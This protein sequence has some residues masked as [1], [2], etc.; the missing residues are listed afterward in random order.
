MLVDRRRKFRQD[1]LEE[2]WDLNAGDIYHTVNVR[3]STV[4]KIAIAKRS[5]SSPTIVVGLACGSI[6]TCDLRTA[7]AFNYPNMSRHGE[8]TALYCP[9]Y[10][11]N[12]VIVGHDDTNVCI[13]D[14]RRY[15]RPVTLLGTRPKLEPW[16]V[17]HGCHVN[18]SAD[19]RY[20]IELPMSHSQDF[21]HEDDIW[22]YVMKGTSNVTGTKPRKS[23]V[24]LPT[25]DVM[26]SFDL[27]MESGPTLQLDV[28]PPRSRRRKSDIS[29]TDLLVGPTISNPE[30]TGH[31]ITSRSTITDS[32]RNNRRQNHT[33]RQLTKG[34]IERI[35][36]GN[37]GESTTRATRSVAKQ[38]AGTKLF[39]SFVASS[40]Q[41]TSTITTNRVPAISNDGTTVA[42]SPIK[43]AVPL[44]ERKSTHQRAY[45]MA[46]SFDT[47][48]D[49]NSLFVARQKGYIEQFDGRNYRLIDTFN[50]GE[51]TSEFTTEE[52]TYSQ[53]MQIMSRDGGQWIIFNMANMIGVMDTS[54]RCVTGL[55]N[56]HWIEHD[57]LIEVMHIFSN[58]QTI[59]KRHV[60]D[61]CGLHSMRDIYGINESGELFVVHPGRR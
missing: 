24:R 57:G 51:L 61:F 21:E 30:S 46:T 34:H 18:Y 13:W 32:D 44:N 55:R 11:D 19:T 33:R 29:I 56:L 26:S 4:K 28:T 8:V 9:E 5:C 38:P 6:S 40:V 58:R 31:G 25:Q 39:Q 2:A 47:T 48:P 16:S 35:S 41:Q 49:G 3:Q 12:T 27:N 52:I 10:N 36:V 22:S 23:P 43:R 17:V 7:V 45:G 15:N 1:Y 53:R 50:L 14:L 37:A 59:Q 20:S 54:R 42:T 60:T